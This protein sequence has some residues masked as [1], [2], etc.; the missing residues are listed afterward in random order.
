MA[1]MDIDFEGNG[2]PT[3][4]DKA[5]EQQPSNDDAK[6]ALNGTSDKE[7]ITGKDGSQ[8]NTE[9]SNATPAQ[10][11]FT[12]DES[13]LEEGT[14][15]T[16]DDVQY[17]VDKSGNLI[18]ANGNLHFNKDELAKFL[19]DNEVTDDTEASD[20]SIESLRKEFGIDI[21]DENGKPIEFTNNIEGVKNYVNSIIS[22]KAKEI[23]E[24]AINSLFSENPLL[25]Q[26]I[27]Y[28]AVNGSPQ[29]FGDMP[30][31]SGIEL[32]KDD[33]QQLI[34]VIKMAASEFGNKSMTDSYI[35]YLDD[36]GSLYDEAQKQLDALIEKDNKL[37]LEI[38][39]NANERRLAEEQELT[40]YWNNVHEAIN[41]RTIGDYKIPE[42]FVKEKDGRKYTLTP[43]DFYRYVSRGVDR[44]DGNMTDYQRDLAKLSADELMNKNLVDAWLMFTGGSYK[45]LVNMANEKEKVQKLVYTTK[46]NRTNKSI[47]INKT[48][49]KNN[50]SSNNIAF[51]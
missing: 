50:S 6:T 22:I 30:D 38:E 8:S 20:I 37:R 32:N 11:S 48:T 51:E 13:Q 27:D 14:T 31:R 5:L 4:D 23:Q 3:P 12:G 28:V 47:R 36:S 49:S 29:G 19:K 46:Q 35:K 15:V 25:K 42:S 21:Q 40:E 1:E 39:K 17:T 43:D 9:E 33:K 24:G 41:K 2:L 18:D 16:I 34:A 44:G 45:D 10:S 26:F 7:D